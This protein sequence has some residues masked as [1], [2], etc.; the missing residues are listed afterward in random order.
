MLFGNK[1]YC[2]LHGCAFNV[3]SGTSEYAPAIDY[4]PIF[5]IEEKDNKIWLYF[6]A[7]PPQKITPSAVTRDY[8]DLR[9]VVIIGCN[10]IYNLAGVSAHACIET[11]RNHEYTGEIT[12]ITKDTKLPYD[13]S[14][15][16]K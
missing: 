3:Q 6:P 2:P 14:Q 10:H 5:Y 8:N 16:T 9:K 15:L 12:M 1:L 4:L 11:L 7:L 13:K